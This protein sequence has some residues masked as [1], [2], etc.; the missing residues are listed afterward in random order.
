TLD[1]RLPAALEELGLEEPRET[2]LV[3]EVLGVGRLPLARGRVLCEGA[4]VLRRRVVG[5]AE[6]A[7]ERAVADEV[8][9]AAD[10]RGEVAVCGAREPRVAEVARVV[11]RLLQRA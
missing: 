10:R 2:E 5:G 8:R 6:L 9:V 4:E 1:G 7:Q 3:R 11:A